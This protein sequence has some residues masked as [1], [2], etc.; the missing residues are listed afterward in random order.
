MSLLF[1]HVSSFDCRG[2]LRKSRADCSTVGLYCVTIAWQEICKRSF[3]IT[4]GSRRFV[5][6]DCWTHTSWQLMQRDSDM[7]IPV[8][9]VHL[10]FVK[11]SMSESVAMLPQVW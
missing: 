5:A 2:G 6:W 9:H 3:Y 8:S 1:K 7:M 4:V 10:N 11:R